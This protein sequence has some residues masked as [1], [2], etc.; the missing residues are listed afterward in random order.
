MMKKILLYEL[1]RETLKENKLFYKKA[2]DT[3]HGDNYDYFS[4]QFNYLK[5]KLIIL[6]LNFLLLSLELF[7]FS[8]RKMLLI[9]KIGNLKTTCVINAQ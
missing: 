9:Y 8:C 6:I 5:N 1:K 2:I 4:F 7:S 3:I